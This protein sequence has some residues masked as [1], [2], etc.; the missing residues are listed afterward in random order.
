MKVLL[1]A[2]IPKLGYF[3]DV[4]DV[5]EGYARNYLLPQGKAVAPSEGNLKEIEDE[6]AHKAEER[7][8]AKERVVKTAEEVN[9]A[10]GSVVVWSG[11]S[12]TPWIW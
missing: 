8:L 9:G 2:D 1:H 6:R 5:S 10:E 4:V 12:L 7:H 11:T 3:G